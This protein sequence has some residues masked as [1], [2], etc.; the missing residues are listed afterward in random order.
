MLLTINVVSIPHIY[1]DISKYDSHGGIIE[2]IDTSG[3]VTDILNKMK[4]TKEKIIKAVKAENLQEIHKHSVAIHV[5]SEILLEKTG[6]LSDI[7]AQDV[8][9]DIDRLMKTTELFHIYADQK[10]QKNTLKKGLKLAKLFKLVE[11]QYSQDI[12]LRFEKVK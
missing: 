12:V 8:C 3:N 9:K 10:D 2:K 5:F 7:E 11:K 4:T 1:A 6:C